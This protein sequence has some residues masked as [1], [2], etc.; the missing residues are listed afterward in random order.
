MKPMIGNLD[1]HEI[2]DLC[3]G[4][5]GM[6]EAEAQRFKSIVLG[7]EWGDTKTADIPNGEWGR[8]LD[9]ATIEE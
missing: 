8:M 4:G 7:S 9:E 3:D 6:T 5:G 2:I 1:L